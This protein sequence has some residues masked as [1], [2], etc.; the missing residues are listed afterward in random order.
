MAKAEPQTD[1]EV[2]A[3][4]DAMIAGVPGVERK[5]AAMPYVSINGNMVAM[6][7][8]A[9]IIGVRLGKDELAAFMAAGGEPF[10]GTPGFIN[11][12]YGGVPSAMLADR[13]ALKRWFRKSHAYASGLKPKKTTRS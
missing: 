6:I 8:K 12:E 9:G 2:I 4:F 5:G 1:P 11:K 10:E 7:S 3:A 13:A